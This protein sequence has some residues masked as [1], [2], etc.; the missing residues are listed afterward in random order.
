MDKLRIGFAVFM[1]ILIAGSI[2]MA[3]ISFHYESIDSAKCVNKGYVFVDR[4]CLDIK[5]IEL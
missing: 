1:I 5:V 4:Q 3:F 2:T